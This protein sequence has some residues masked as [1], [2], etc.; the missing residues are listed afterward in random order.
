MLNALATQS[1]VGMVIDET[2]SVS[3]DSVRG[4]PVPRPRSVDLHAL[5]ELV[6]PSLLY[7]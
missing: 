7:D 1:N 5:R 3:A 2:T 6:K 4:M